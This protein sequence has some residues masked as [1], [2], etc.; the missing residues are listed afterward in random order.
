MKLSHES[1]DLSETPLPVKLFSRTSGAGDEGCFYHWHEQFELYYVLRGG[2]RL[3]CNGREGWLRGGDVALVNWCEPHKSL[4]F[5]N[6]TLHY[7]IQV[8][9]AS[10]FF[11]A[12]KGLSGLPGLLSQNSEANALLDGVIREYREKNEGYIQVI[13]GQ[14]ISFFGLLRR[15]GEGG[16]PDHAEE[17]LT[18]VKHVLTYIHDHYNQALRLDDIAADA[19]ISKPYLCRVFKKHTGDTITRYIHSLRLNLAKTLITEGSSVS[20]AGA[21]VGY[22][23]YNYFSRRFKKEFGRPPSRAGKA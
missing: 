5:L 11:Q 20:R 15:S 18:I 10:P 2:V 22:D 23:D 8:D 17:C 16:S 9:T 12:V 6:D 7:I 14:M 4:G 13:C 21:A 19:G 3:L 1:V